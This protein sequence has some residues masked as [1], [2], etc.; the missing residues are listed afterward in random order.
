MLRSKTRATTSGSSSGSSHSKAK[1]QRSIHEFFS[2]PT[3]RSTKLR[4]TRRSLEASA[5]NSSFNTI[6]AIKKY[7]DEP[8]QK[9]INYDMMDE[10]SSE[11]PLLQCISQ[12]SDSGRRPKPKK[13]DFTAC[14][15]SQ[16]SEPDLE[17]MHTPVRFGVPLTN[18]SC[19]TPMHQYSQDEMDFL[20]PRDQPVIPLSNP[21]TPS[22]LKKR[23]RLNS[24][25]EL[26]QEEPVQN[27]TQDMTHM[28]VRHVRKG[29]PSSQTSIDM[30]SPQKTSVNVVINAKRERANGCDTAG[31]FLSAESYVNPFAPESMTESG[32]KK[33]SRRKR[34]SFPPTW[35]GATNGSPVAKYLSDF[36]ELGLI[37]SGSFSKVYKCIKKIDGWVYAVKKSKRH[38]RGKA[39]TERALREVQALAALSS[40]NHVVRYFDAWIE[41]DLLYIQ[42]EYLEGCSLASFVKKCAPQK[43]PEETLCKLLCHL[44]QAL[45]DMHNKKMVHMDV[46]LQNVLV[47]PDEVYKLGDLGTVAHLDGSMEIREGDNRYLSRELLE[48]NRNNLRAGDIFALGATIY[49]L[50]LGTTLAS[51]GEEWQ[52][53]RDGDLVMFR[54][55]S[56][57]LQHLI[58]NMMHPDAL[59]RPLAEDILQHE[60]VLPFR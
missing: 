20:T 25:V 51:G 22:P 28:D 12:N 39:D 10:E 7:D 57:S 60:V 37:G 5:K 26:I 55:Y 9:R 46:K 23:P 31:S 17:P 15:S 56:N 45:F 48:G 24:Q 2:Q 54:Q 36:S 33:I 4:K 32:K 43:V 34:R 27:L 58:A 13:I 11:E 1:K 42:L 44:A 30:E 19:Y 14:S 35:V 53:I 29:R 41:D 8:I 6:P 18:Q 16:R 47:G 49:E 3:V 21:T 40:S 38:F 52:K 59:Q 50:A